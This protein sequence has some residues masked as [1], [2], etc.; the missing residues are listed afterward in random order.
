MSCEQES[1][2]DP[3]QE[4]FCPHQ[5]LFVEEGGIVQFQETIG[6]VSGLME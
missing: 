3:E 2:L 4:S 5:F 6:N 1:H